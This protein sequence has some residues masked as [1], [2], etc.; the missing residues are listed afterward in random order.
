MKE[1]KR[2]IEES[3][4]AKKKLLGDREMLDAVKK[5]AGLCIAAVR[6]GNKILLAGNG[7]SAADAQHIAGELVNRFMIDRPALA[8]ISLS[9][10]TSIL[11]SIANDTE[12]TNV[13]SRQVEAIG[14]EGDVLL[15]ISTSGNSKNIVNAIN[16]AKEKSIKVI[17]FLGGIGGLIKDMTD[18]NVLIPSDNIQRIQEGHITAAHIIC[19]L[20]ERDLYE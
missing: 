13:F 3:I 5:A 20:I 19:E 7:G 14:R 15:V 18:V 9:T 10:D 2:Q 4:E 1:I 17:G 16:A 8:A 6:K 11:T 12:F